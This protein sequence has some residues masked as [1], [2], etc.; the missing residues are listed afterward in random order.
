VAAI[1]LDAAVLFLPTLIIFSAVAGNQP[2]VNVN[3]GASGVPGADWEA[4]ALSLLVALAY[5]AFLDGSR[6]GQTVG[7]MALGIAVRDVRTGAP[8]GAGRA[9]VRRFLFFL[10]YLGFVFLFVLNA[11]WPLWDPRRQ[12]LHD[13]PVSSCVVDIR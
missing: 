10:T 8:V 2:A 12:A 5:F 6:R 9:L 13:K 11:L 3:A 7:K 1:L 4:L